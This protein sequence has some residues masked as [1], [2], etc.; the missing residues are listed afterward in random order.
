M[1]GSSTLMAA[2]AVVLSRAEWPRRCAMVGVGGST[3]FCVVLVLISVLLC[4]GLMWR[5]PW[6]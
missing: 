4:Q 6:G 1:L 3:G 5:W 2:M